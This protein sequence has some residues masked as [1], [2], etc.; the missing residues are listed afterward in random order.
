MRAALLSLLVLATSASA[1]GKYPTFLADK[2]CAAEKLAAVVGEDARVYLA[3]SGA[4]TERTMHLAVVNMAPENYGPLREFGMGF[5]EPAIINASGQP[6]WVIEIDKA[7]RT[8]TWSLSD[9]AVSELGVP[10]R[11]RVSGFTIHLKPGW[12]TSGWWSARWG[13]R[14]PTRYLTVAEAVSSVGRQRC[15]NL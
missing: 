14:G 7:H 8:V 6:G 12:R 9:A 3:C 4:G 2:A 13:D 5:C 10:S 1:V 11:A 15:R